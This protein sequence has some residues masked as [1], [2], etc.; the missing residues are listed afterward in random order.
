MK[1]LS[2]FDTEETKITLGQLY[3]LDDY[4]FKCIKIRE[5]GINTY[6]VCDK[7]GTYLGIEKNDK[8]HIND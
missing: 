7:N 1:Q 4:F 6:E 2:I 3:T 5:S 8:G